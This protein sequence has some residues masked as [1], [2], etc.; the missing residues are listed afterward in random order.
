MEVLTKKMSDS[1][2]TMKRFSLRERRKA[3]RKFREQA[4]LSLEEV[5][6]RADLSKSMVSKFELGHRDLSPDAFGRLQKVVTKALAQH[7]ISLRRKEDAEKR[8]AAETAKT[9]QTFGVPLS[10]LSSMTLETYTESC[11]RMEQK[12]GPHWQEVFQALFDA[13]EKQA[14]LEARIEELRDLLAVETHKAL[15]E[16]EA[17]DIRERIAAREKDSDG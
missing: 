12:Y 11:K 17:R 4:G 7:K 6:K 13:G 2:A 5:A 10:S 1:E 14:D 16:T 15:D 3:L 8:N 9:A